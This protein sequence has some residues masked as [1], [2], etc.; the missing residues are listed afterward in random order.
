MPG[1]AA[2]R[3]YWEAAGNGNLTQSIQIFGFPISEPFDEQ[4]GAAACG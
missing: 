1:I 3:A 2:I 4:S